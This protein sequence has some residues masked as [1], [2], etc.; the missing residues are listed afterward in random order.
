MQKKNNVQFRQMSPGR[1]VPLC[2]IRLM[3]QEHNNCI[4]RW[5]TVFFYLLLFPLGLIAVMSPSLKE[6][7]STTVNNP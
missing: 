7:A 1:K 2:V 4:L 5:M 3:H 6:L